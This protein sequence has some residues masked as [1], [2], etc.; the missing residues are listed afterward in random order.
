MDDVTMTDEE[1]LDA[2]YQKDDDDAF[3]QLDRKYR[4]RMTLA[5]L[6]K[7]PRMAGRREKAEELAGRALA[8]AADTKGRPK[9]RWDKTK[10]LVGPWLSSILHNVVVSYLRLKTGHDL[11]F[12]DLENQG[13]GQDEAPRI[14]E[15]IPTTL[16]GPEGNLLTK[17]RAQALKECVEELPERERLVVSMQ[18]WEGLLNK[19][20][21]QILKV[22]E[23]TVSRASDKA[24]SHLRDCLKRK[25]VVESL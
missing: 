9:A 23:P 4:D 7:L 12:S 2:Y 25:H 8:L 21:A 13:P 22:S 14:E 11:V 16:P 5:A 17:D 18:F 19:D 3:A 6:V 10:G 20:I 15:A 1:L 24:M